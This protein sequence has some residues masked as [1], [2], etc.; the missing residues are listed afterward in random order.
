MSLLR[1]FT[2]RSSSAPSGDSG[3]D[4]PAAD[5]APADDNALGG[6]MFA[7]LAVKAPAAAA[8]SVGFD[9]R[10]AAPSAFTFLSSVADEPVD[11]SPTSSFSFIGGVPPEPEPAPASSD[12]DFF[13]GLSV[14]I[15]SVE[16]S[17]A[18]EPTPAPLIISEAPA[19]GPPTQQ[20]TL[21]SPSVP[22]PPMDSYESQLK[23]LND[24]ISRIMV[25]HWKAMQ[26][27][28]HDEAA[29]RATKL[30]LL[31]R[32]AVANSDLESL[33]AAQG[34]AVEDEVGRDA[35]DIVE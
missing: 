28:D 31:Q 20:E 19:P 6:S 35:R 1:V 26:A 29:V 5:A 15:G 12:V 4:A 24:T 23:A 10:P 34:K 3:A 21:L 32:I 13:S 16:P 11:P 25:D 22:S 18:S 9:D 8:D 30:D 14:P 33:V 2:G 17:P 7:G 27:I